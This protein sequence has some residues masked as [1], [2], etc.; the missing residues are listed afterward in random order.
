MS[1]IIYI[2]LILF[3]S[4]LIQIILG[5]AGIIIPLISLAIFY[6]T[7]VFGW[8]EGIISAVISGIF[9][10]IVYGRT[11]LISPFIG[12]VTVFIAI[13]W[14]HKGELGILSF[15]MIPSGII[16]LLYI[17]PFVYYTYQKTEHGLILALESMGILIISGAI[18]TILFPLIVRF[19]DT[20]NNP[21]GFNYYRTA[22]EKLEKS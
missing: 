17:I 16:S 22:Q 21:L 6:L 20:I 15:Q 7:I 2:S 13:I 4:A 18:T 8:E 19:L 3:I 11:L 12:I 14:L 10:D 9:L 1:K 5:N